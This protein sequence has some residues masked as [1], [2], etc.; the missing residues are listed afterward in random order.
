MERSRHNE[1]TV[2]HKGGGC[3]VVHILLAVLEGSVQFLPPTHIM[4]SIR[5]PKSVLWLY[6][7]VNTRNQL[8]VRIINSAVDLESYLN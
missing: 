6:G 5:P 3:V 7:N 4:N 2:M 8:L 1:I